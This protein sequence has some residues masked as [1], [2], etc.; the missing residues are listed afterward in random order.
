MCGGHVHWIRWIVESPSELYIRGICL[1]LTGY[2][3]HFLLGDS[4]HFHL[5]GSTGR[6]IWNVQGNL[7]SR[8]V[9]NICFVVTFLDLS[10]VLMSANITC[11]FRTSRLDKSIRF[12]S[13]LRR[14]FYQYFLSVY[15]G[16]LVISS[17]LWTRWY[18]NTKKFK[19]HKISSVVYCW[20]NVFSGECKSTPYEGKDHVALL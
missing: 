5:V 1:N 12:I 14:K 10:Y 19:F 9:F 17:Q 6:G 11:L 16:F 15:N 3:R 7:F 4:V 18:Y 13:C 2:L 20:I 8:R